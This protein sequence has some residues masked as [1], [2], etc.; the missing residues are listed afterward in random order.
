MLL[1]LTAAALVALASPAAWASPPDKDVFLDSFTF[2]DTWTCPGLTITQHNE[3][4]DTVTVFSPTR[5][6]VQ[7]HGV[8]TLSA[9]GK[10]LTSNFSAQIFLDPTSTVEK[11]VGTVYNVQVPGRGRVLLDAGNVVYDYSTFPL[12][13]L[14]LAG[15]HQALT[16]DVGELCGYLAA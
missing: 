4:R 9:N 5:V 2:D 6:R 11:V 14:H 3:E 1:T 8:A 16:G 12:T 13:I 10:T 7:R 15:P